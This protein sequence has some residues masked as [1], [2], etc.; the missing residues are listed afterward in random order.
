[1][2]HRLLNGLLVILTV[3]FSGFAAA[4]DISGTVSDGSGP[5][6]GASVVVKG[7]QNSASTDL[8]GKYAIKNAGANAVLVFSYIGL[9]SQEVAAAGKSVV[10]VVLKDDQEKLKEVVVIGYGSVK[11]KD[12]TGAVDQIGSKDF[13]NVSS[14]SPAQ[15][16]RGKVA[17]VQVTSSSGEPGAAVSLRVRG[18]AS[19]RSGVNALIVVDGVPLDGGNVSSGGENIQ[20]LGSSSA[21]NPLNFINQNDIESI[22]VLKDASS[23]AIY[24]ARGANGVIL[25]TTKRAKSKE[26]ELSYSSSAQFGS[27]KSDFKMLNAQEFVAAG[28]TNNGSSYNWEDAILRNTV[29]TNHDIAFAK[30]S[31]NSSTRVSFGISNTEGIVKNTG[32]DKYSAALFNSNDFFNGVLKVETRLNYT[33]LND[34]TTLIT[35]NAGFIGNLIG[36]ALA[37]N[38]TNPIYDNSPDGYFNPGYNN[39]VGAYGSNTYLNP[40]QLLDA[41]SDRTKTNRL[42][43]SVKTSLKITKDIKYQLLVGIENSSSI[44]KSQLAPTIE[45][46]DVSSPTEAG[47]ARINNQDN[48]N[49]TFEHTLTYNKSFNDNFSFDVLG[50]YSYYDYNVSGGILIGSGFSQDQTNLIDNIEGATQTNFRPNS[51]ANR[52]EIQSYFGRA[53]FTIFKNLLLTGT[54][55]RDGSSKFGEN[56]KYGNFPSGAIAYKL[57]N[58]KEG[59]LNNVKIRA[60]YGITGNSEIPVNSAVNKIEYVNG[61][62]TVVSNGNPELQWESTTTYGAGIDFDLLKN[63]LSGTLDYFVRDTENLI[64]GVPAGATLPSGGFTQFQNTSNG[65]LRGTGIEVSLNYKVLDNDD[66]RWDISGNASFIKSEI[67]DFI[68]VFKQ[69]TGELNGAGLSGAFSQQLEN[70]HPIYEYFLQEFV[71]YDGAGNSLYLDANGGTTGSPL[72][73]YTGKQALPKMNVGFNTT[74]GYKNLDLTASFYGAFGHY[75]YNNTANAYFFKGSLVNGGRNITPEAAAT[76]QSAGDSNPGSTKYLEKGDFIRMGNITLGYTFKNDLLERYKIKAARLF[77]NGSNLLLFTDYSGFD[78]EVDTAKPVNGYPSSGID[79]L[80]YPREK[81]VSVGVNLTF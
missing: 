43:G 66:F 7:T 46:Q 39:P 57:V 41:Y 75:I 55:R 33:N 45:I 19:L 70:G 12:A 24:G 73:K 13:D 71:G 3:L 35:N 17:G 16:L 64:F 59:F 60:T 2:K 68:S 76:A 30:S 49:K 69:A 62:Q 37:W 67:K 58:E 10:N 72:K 65:V 5:L 8:N 15:L 77:V 56:K 79:F 4:Q 81:N 28:G 52:T 53:N 38:P 26:P 14:V 18:S 51:F 47:V 9:A 80:S 36:T 78:P 11:K 20:G 48:F 25:I 22:S 54:I 23:T 42:L 63:K 50:G 32:L 27:F 61:A 40:V 31:E 44:R 1:M 34:R 6:P 29:S 21:R 74:F